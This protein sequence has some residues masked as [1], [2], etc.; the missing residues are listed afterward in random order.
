MKLE[1]RNSMEQPAFQRYETLAGVEY[2]I[3]SS[4]GKTYYTVPLING[5]G[6]GCECKHVQ[7]KPTCSHQDEAE[8]QEKLY[9]TAQHPQEKHERDWHVD[10]PLNGN[11]AFSLLR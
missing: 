3:L 2:E 6:A 4:N 9:Q 11:K 7:F 8:K 5:K 10:A 1:G